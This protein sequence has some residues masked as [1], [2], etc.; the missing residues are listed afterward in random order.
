M[1]NLAT[2]GDQLWLD[3]NKYHP[4]FVYPE[5]PI[6]HTSQG[7]MECSL[8]IGCDGASSPIAHGLGLSSPKYVGY[9]AIR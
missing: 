2:C 5:Y 6:L 7:D 1:I 4:L 8:I 9:C 3:S